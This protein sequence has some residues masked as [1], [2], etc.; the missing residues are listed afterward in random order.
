[1]YV[2]QEDVRHTS[3][4][5]E[6]VLAEDETGYFYGDSDP[7]DLQAFEG[8]AQHILIWNDT[9]VTAPEIRAYVQITRKF[10]E[11]GGDALGGVFNPSG[12]PAAFRA[13]EALE[14]QLAAVEE[15]ESRLAVGL[16]ANV[17]GFANGT[18]SAKRSIEFPF[19][20]TVDIKGFINETVRN[21]SYPYDDG[22]PV[23]ESYQYDSNDINAEARTSNSGFQGPLG[24][25]AYRTIGG[26]VMDTTQY[27][28]TYF[29]NGTNA[30][31]V[32]NLTALEM[33]PPI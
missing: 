10:I 13:F 6:R 7:N 17:S 23:V 28:T 19:E 22:Q 29:V 4:A 33:A 15:M 24:D 32:S 31:N 11:R 20:T 9:A 14:D 26:G 27:I 30:S 8:L 12:G 21:Y 18:R 25:E 16:D 3:G 2:A 1:L 5:L